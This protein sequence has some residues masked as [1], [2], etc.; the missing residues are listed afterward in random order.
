VSQIARVTGERRWE[1]RFVGSRAGQP[2]PFETIPLIWERAFGGFEP[3]PGDPEKPDY[4]QRNPVGRGF[5]AKGA[6]LI[7]GSMLPNIERPDD[8]MTHHRSRPEPVGFGF[9]GPSWEHRIR[10]AGTYDERWTD[11]RSPLLPLDFD[12]RF[13]SA[14]APGLTTGAYLRGD[15]DVLAVN[16]SPEGRLHF[17]LPGLDAPEFLLSLRG[18]GDT[19]VVGNLDTLIV[20]LESRVVILIWRALHALRDGPLDVSAMRIRVANAPE[21]LGSEAAPTAAPD[22]VVSMFPDS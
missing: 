13:F 22:N 16:A 4:E 10:F 8:P 20:D 7:E 14:A 2:E 11:S 5:R 9:T 21:R 6:S 15:E 17:R 3:D 12:R 19:T 1:K 18:S